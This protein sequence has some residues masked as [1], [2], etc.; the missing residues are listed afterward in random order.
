MKKN[1]NS[2]FFI[3]FL[4]ITV[5]CCT[6]INNDKYQEIASPIITANGLLMVKYPQGIPA[7]VSGQEYKEL[8]KENYSILYDKL[9]PYDVKIYKSGTFFKVAVYYDKLQVLLD[10]SCTQNRIDCWVYNG[11]CNPDT[12]KV[13]CIK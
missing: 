5:S 7:E 12:L 6:T 4:L 1:I 8:L 9:N 3:G 11:E 10:L 13:D 2:L